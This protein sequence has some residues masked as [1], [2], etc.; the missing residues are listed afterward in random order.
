MNTIVSSENF[1][2]Y[3]VLTGLHILISKKPFKNVTFSTNV[4]GSDPLDHDDFFATLLRIHYVH[5]LQR[6]LGE[7]PENVKITNTDSRDPDDIMKCNESELLLH[8]D[9]PDSSFNNT[10]RSCLN[11]SDN[12]FEREGIIPTEV[13]GAMYRNTIPRTLQNRGWAIRE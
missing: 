11:M 3:F 13:N 12:H 5:N 4:S 2:D 10:V 6:Y 7:L 9:L 1:I 8:W